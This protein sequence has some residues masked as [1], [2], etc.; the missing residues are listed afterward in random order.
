MLRQGDRRAGRSDWAPEDR[1]FKEKAQRLLEDARNESAS[2]SPS[3]LPEHGQY[4]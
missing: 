4:V 1:E 3:P 2:A